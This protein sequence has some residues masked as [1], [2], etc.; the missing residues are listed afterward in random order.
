MMSDFCDLWYWYLYGLGV[1]LPGCL[2]DVV[3]MYGL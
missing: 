3:G 2:G 1:V